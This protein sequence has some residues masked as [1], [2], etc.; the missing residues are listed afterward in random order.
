MDRHRSG[1]AAPS[2]PP[3][4]HSEHLDPV[5]SSLLAFL[6]H[7]LLFTLSH[8]VSYTLFPSALPFPPLS[9]PRFCFLLPHLPSLSPDVVQTPVL[10]CVSPAP[11]GMSQVSSWISSSVRVIASE[12]LF[13]N[14]S[15]DTKV[16][17]LKRDFPGLQLF[18]ADLLKPGSF[19][20]AFDG[21]EILF[22]T[23]SPFQT[24]VKDAQ[25]E[26]VDPAVNGTIDVVNT[27]LAVPTL[28]RIVLTSSVATIRRPEKEE[29]YISTD[30][31]WNNFANINNLPYPFSKVE[32]EKKAWELVNAH[33][34]QHPE[35][36][37]RL[38][39]VLPSWVMGPPFGTR[40]DGVS[41]GT[42]VSWLDESQVE[43]GVR[44]QLVGCVDVRD[45]AATHLAAAE[46]ENASGRYI[47]SHEKPTH[48]SR[49]GGCVQDVVPQQEVPFSCRG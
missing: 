16:K 17:H 31:D 23:A 37:V 29:G 41:V 28:K 9:S 34:A 48:P 42:I 39:T 32:A 30:K 47:C 43:K 40:V 11:P 6:V 20:Q 44:P 33:N 18:E 38:V 27:A 1:S 14:L 49:H 13:R 3:T 10:W 12:V 4:D 15:D 22:H 24:N 26:L 36:Q 46:K 25:K 5:I 45:V 19:K 8:A 2:P 7:Y 35:H 21:I